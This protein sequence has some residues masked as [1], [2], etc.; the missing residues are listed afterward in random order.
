MF[1]AIVKKVEG[2]GNES[3]NPGKELLR[4][5]YQELYAARCFCIMAQIKSI[6]YSLE[7]MI[8]KNTTILQVCLFLFSRF[9]IECR[10]S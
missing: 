3:Q 8:K 5:N 7:K 6:N 10:G 1:C 9:S 4:N 2:A